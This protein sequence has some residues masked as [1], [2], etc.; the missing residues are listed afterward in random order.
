MTIALKNLKNNSQMSQYERNMKWLIDNRII[1][2]I[3][4]WSD[5]PTSDNSKYMFYEYGTHQCYELFRSPAKINTF[6]SLKWHLLV[7][8]WANPQLTQ[9][10]FEILANY[11]AEH[12]NGFCTFTISPTQL[13]RIIHDVSMCDL[14]QP[15][16]N[17]SRKVIF[18]YGNG[19]NKSEKLKIVGELIG[20]TKKISSDDIYQCMLDLHD[21]GQKIT[22]RRISELLGCAQRT[23]HRNMPHELKKEKELLNN[24][25]Q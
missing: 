7:L 4:P 24:D 22:I 25:L 20:K 18:K 5:E 2:I 8:W 17:K 21:D 3:H 6:K 15:P 16:K 23:I 19:L 10:K 1:S 14:E 13:E 11:I 9:D 12:S